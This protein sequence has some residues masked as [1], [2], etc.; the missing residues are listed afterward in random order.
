MRRR[1]SLSLG[2]VTN[3]GGEEKCLVG[4]DDL[5]E[6][7][8][9]DG[10]GDGDGDGGGGVGDGAPSRPTPTAVDRCL[11]RCPGP[12]SARLTIALC[13]SVG[14]LISFGIRCNIAVA[15]VNMT[16]NTTTDDG[17]NYTVREGGGG[18]GEGEGE[19]GNSVGL[20]ISDGTRRRT[21]DYQ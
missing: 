11:L 7:R 3:R 13:S 5:N 6:S 1:V 2:S 21:A 15:I 18:E 16:R 9:D 17:A 19:G 14:L 4:Y 12:C 20:L 10:D 8:D